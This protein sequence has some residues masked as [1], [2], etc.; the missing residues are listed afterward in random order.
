MAKG[1]GESALDVL[2]HVVNAGIF[3]TS[4]DSSVALRLTA[5]GERL[6]DPQR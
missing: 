2:E 6:L 3:Y 1:D 4:H 5:L